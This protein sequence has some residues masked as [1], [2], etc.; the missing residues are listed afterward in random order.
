MAATDD[1]AL[2]ARARSGDDEAF[3]EL[4]TRHQRAMFAIARAYFAA[5][6]DADDAVQEAF[7]RAF[8]ALDQLRD[9]SRF[10]GW[11]ARIT[12]NECL[13]TLR[14]RTDKMSLADFASTEQFK[15][16]LGQ[17]YLTPATL[18]S[19]GEEADQ[20]KAAIGRL[21]EPQRVAVMLH[22]AADMTY[23]EIASYLDVPYTTVV[24]RLH[25]ARQ[26]LRRTLGALRPAE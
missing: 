23:N 9:K 24:G 10:A 15:P 1:A 8:E 5:E 17:V 19:Q 13:A 12:V 7:V 22:Y 26:A 20:L 3:G 2:V 11:L 14:S 6:A 25:T 18:A 4:V 16:R 21:P